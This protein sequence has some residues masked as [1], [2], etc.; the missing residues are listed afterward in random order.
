MANESQN[1]YAVLL[2]TN[3]GMTGSMPLLLSALWLT[4]AG[5]YTF[6]DISCF[7]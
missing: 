3:L 6:S 2:Y 7:A 5:K 1:N 4:T